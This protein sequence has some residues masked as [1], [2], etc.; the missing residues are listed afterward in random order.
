MIKAAPG[1]ETEN[2]ASAHRDESCQ[3]EGQA[4]LE[5]LEA[6][7]GKP[8]E[9]IKGIIEECEAL[10]IDAGLIACGQVSSITVGLDGALTLRA[11]C[12]LLQANSDQES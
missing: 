2:Q 6:A 4:G 12:R 9:A 3:V 5:L 11:G 8:C 7:Q 1:P 10:S